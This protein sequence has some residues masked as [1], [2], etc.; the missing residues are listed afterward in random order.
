[1]RSFLVLLIVAGLALAGCAAEADE[2]VPASAD[3]ASA[4]PTGASTT[5]AS[6]NT[7]AATTVEATTVEIVDFDFEPVEV[8]VAVGDTVTWNQS[9]TSTHTVDFSDGEESEDLTEGSSYSRTFDQAG[10]YPFACFFH[11]QM[12]GTVSVL[13]SSA[14][15]N[16]PQPARAV[17][18]M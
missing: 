14:Q 5:D 2:T 7:D 12:T 17:T 9:G 10:E 3:P 6:E 13:P 15:P 16:G 11:P 1:M 4:D 8:E 18:Q